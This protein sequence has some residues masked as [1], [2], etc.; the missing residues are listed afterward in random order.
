[1]ED[2]GYI[3]RKE[4]LK[5]YIKRQEGI[6]GEILRINDFVENIVR[7]IDADDSERDLRLKIVTPIIEGFRETAIALEN[8]YYDY[9][10]NDGEY[11]IK[12]VFEVESSIRRMM[13]LEMPNF[14]DTLKKQ[15]DVK[16]APSK[17]KVVGLTDDGKNSLDKAKTMIAE[18][19]PVFIIGDQFRYERFHNENLVNGLNNL[20]EKTGGAVGTTHT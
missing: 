2:I 6:Y 20:L 1:M 14:I 9:L 19:T 11:G 7:S 8:R 5:T 3:V 10:M 18:Y 15:T 16:I 13:F 4:A 17:R 12:N